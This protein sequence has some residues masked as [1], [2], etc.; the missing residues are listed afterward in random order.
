MTATLVL[1]SNDPSI[2]SMTIPLTGNAESAENPADDDVVGEDEVILTEEI[3]GCGCDTP[4]SPVTGA[5][6]AIAAAALLAR[7]RRA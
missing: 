1:T 6:G 2:P 7:R 3:G 5:L 4:G